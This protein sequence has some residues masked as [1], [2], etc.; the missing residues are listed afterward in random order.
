MLASL[1]KDIEDKT[2]LAPEEYVDLTYGKTYLIQYNNK[3]LT[4]FMRPPWV[5]IIIEDDKGVCAQSFQESWE[6]CWK[7]PDSIES[8]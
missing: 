3:N 6:L 7:L 1:A 8:I 2:G 4:I 5:Y